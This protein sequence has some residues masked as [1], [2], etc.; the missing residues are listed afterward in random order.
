MII[1]IRVI[2]VNLIII[3]KPT[4]RIQNQNASSTV[5]DSIANQ[6]WLPVIS[7]FN[8]SQLVVVDL[9]FFNDASAI[10][11]HQ[12]A[13][14]ASV[15]NLILNENG[16][17]VVPNDDASEF[18]AV[19]LIVLKGAF[20]VIDDDAAGKAGMDSVLH[21]NGI[22]IGADLH[23][24]RHVL[25]DLVV[26]QH[27]LRLPEEHPACFGVMNG[28]SYKLWIPSFQYFHVC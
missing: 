6:R 15:V 4:A 25:E 7:N 18:I 13:A 11:M 1:N 27:A 28:V 21:E 12:N 23:R 9:V 20:G 22:G 19:N 17:G 26:P 10:V 16:I 24:G 8:T 3:Q 14:L 5:E 2:I